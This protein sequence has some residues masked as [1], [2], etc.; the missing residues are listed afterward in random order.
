MEFNLADLFE[1]VADHVPTRE[2]LVC[3][4]SRLTYR[5]LDERANRLAH[6]LEEQGVR[7]ADHVGL[8]LYNCTEFVEAMLACFKL[9]AVPINVNYRYVSDELAYLFDNADLAG[10][11]YHRELCPRIRDMPERGALLIEVDGGDARP[12]R[13]DAEPGDGIGAVPYEQ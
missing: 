1:S 6:G 9:R 8:Y 12:A 2:A 13:P 3:G 5:D 11:V 4:S 10:V 7:A